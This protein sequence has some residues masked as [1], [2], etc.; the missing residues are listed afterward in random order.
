[1]IVYNY[2]VSAVKMSDST[3]IATLMELAMRQSFTIQSCIC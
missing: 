1:M 2:S 3:V